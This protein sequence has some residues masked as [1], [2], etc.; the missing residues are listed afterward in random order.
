M[1]E[2]D[3]LDLTPHS[4]KPPWPIAFSPPWKQSSICSLEG[5]GKV[6]TGWI[7]SGPH[8]QFKDWPVVYDAAWKKTMG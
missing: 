2:E 4:T 3:L 8:N 6:A 1:G 7:K 5:K